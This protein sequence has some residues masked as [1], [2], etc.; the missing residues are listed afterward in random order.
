MPRRH[1]ERRIDHVHDE[2]STRHSQNS[3]GGSFPRSQDPFDPHPVSRPDYYDV[4]VLRQDEL[5]S[6]L[7]VSNL[8]LEEKVKEKDRE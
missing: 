4:D 1:L 2:A 7:K 5:V 3:K 8:K 6:T